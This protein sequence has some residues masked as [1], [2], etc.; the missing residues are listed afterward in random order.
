MSHIKEATGSETTED[1]V[2]TTITDFKTI[3]GF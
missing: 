3:M 2:Q 1:M